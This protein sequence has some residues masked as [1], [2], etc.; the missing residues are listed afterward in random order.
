MPYH[1]KQRNTPNTTLR[2]IFSALN[3]FIA[4]M[5]RACVGRKYLSLFEDIRS[6]K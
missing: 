2:S 6:A 1:P 3:P 4:S 5:E